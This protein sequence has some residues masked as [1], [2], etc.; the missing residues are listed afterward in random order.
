[1]ALR[2]PVNY[3]TV[4]AVSLRAACFAH[5]KYEDGSFR[6]CLE[7]LLDAGF[8]RFVVDVFWDAPRATWSL[9]PVSLDPEAPS[10]EIRA[11]RDLREVAEV[12]LST[13]LPWT[14]GM[15]LWQRQEPSSADSSS[16]PHPSAGTTAPGSLGDP[17]AQQISTPIRT[18][19]PAPTGLPSNISQAAHL[20]D[21][22]VECSSTMTL[23]FLSDVL[24]EYLK[25]TGTTL[26]AHIT[27]LILN[28]HAVAAHSS[29]EAPAQQLSASALPREDNRI[30]D[31]LQGN[32]SSYFYTPS[33][34]KE[35]RS[36]VN[37]SWFDVQPA[38]KP[39]PAYYETFRNGDDDSYKT[40][41]GWPTEAYLEF[42]KFRRLL[43]SF[44]SIDPQMKGYNLSSE[45]ETVFNSTALES[46][47]NTT[48]DSDG[49]VKTGCLFSADSSSTPMNSSWAISLAPNI[50]LGEKPSTVNP[51]S[52]ITNLTAC[53]ISPLLN[54]TLSNVTA[55]NDSLPY[56]A[57]ARSTLWSWAP[58]EPTN[59]TGSGDSRRRK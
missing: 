23:S 11:A 3:V 40:S 59:H 34:L 25:D 42:K 16:V 19:G 36:N 20:M 39:N 49:R 53:G 29:P 17:T 27:Y 55:D 7:N 38:N 5:G 58:N 12:T 54:S 45:L 48:F 24:R 46:L 6:K 51:I 4:P 31:V 14:D 22:Q 37:E 21:G 41:N 47:H 8:Q 26:E 15:P 13:Q 33:T 2:V 1:V 43:A 10:L 44:G 28:I 56:L 35:E 9:C 32:L 50:V 52:P 30:S 57:F 18:A